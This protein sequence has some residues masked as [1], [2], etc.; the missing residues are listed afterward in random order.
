MMSGFL[1]QMCE[2]SRQRCATARQTIALEKL[3]EDARNLPPPPRLR[4]HPGGFDVIAEV[5][6]ASPSEGELSSET[7]AGLID[8]AIAY[9]S[10]G[11]AAVSVL[12]E[13]SRFGG[14][15]Q[16]LERIAAALRQ[17]QVPV[18]RKDFIVDVYQVWEAAA[19]GA[20]GVLAIVRVLDD[21][22]IMQILEAAAQT[23]MFVLLEAFDEQDLRRAQPFLHAHDN[24][25]LGLNCRDLQTLQVQASR[26][27][28]LADKFPEDCLRVAESGVS[29]AEDALALRQLGYQF[30]LVGSALMREPSPRGLIAHMLASAR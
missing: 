5:K 26:F 20:G 23:R 12:T 27:R 13:P 29:T 6:K 19:A 16:H 10:A 22:V 21:A 8:R 4:P 25:L 17:Y 9:A 11:A 1:D 14:R 3:V 15:L 30:A 28:Q 18:M 2:L 24:L 7:D